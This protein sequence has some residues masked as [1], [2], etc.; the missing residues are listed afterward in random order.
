MTA[1]L[2]EDTLLI[3]LCYL[4]IKVTVNVSHVIIFAPSLPSYSL[5]TQGRQQVAAGCRVKHVG[6]L[7][8]LVLSKYLSSFLLI[9][10]TPTGLPGGL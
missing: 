3:P 6:L 9:I 4:Q 8:F 2:Y 5:A 10:P 7:L 1:R